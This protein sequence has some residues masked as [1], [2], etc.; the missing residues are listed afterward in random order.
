MR[1]GHGVMWCGGV[2]AALPPPPHPSHT[3]TSPRFPHTGPT[4]YIPDAYE[5]LLLDAV[6]G[7]QSH[8][9]RRDELR[10]AWAIF[11]DLLSAADAGSLP[12]HSYAAGSRGPPQ[13][14]E[15]LA[16]VGYVRNEGY[17]WGGGRGQGAAV[18]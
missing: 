12:I 15:L 5:R 2:C 3:H 7:D 8:F 9:V 1:G 18:R 10:A 6:R 4:T 11:D 14:D 13:A 16:K 17:E